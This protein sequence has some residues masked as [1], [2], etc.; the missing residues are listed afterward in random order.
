MSNL[1]K[2]N[3]LCT[4]KYFV[5]STCKFAMMVLLLLFTVNDETGGT[6]EKLLWKHSIQGHI[7]LFL[8]SR[9]GGGESGEF[10]ILS[11]YFL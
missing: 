2:Q 5:S 11:A 9:L 3:V 4:L 8:H 7:F 1:I 10:L 6:I